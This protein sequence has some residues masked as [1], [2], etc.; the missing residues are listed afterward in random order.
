MDKQNKFLHE[1]NL[2]ES[3]SLIGG[4]PGRDTSLGYDIGWIIGM[5]FGCQRYGLSMHM[6]HIAVYMAK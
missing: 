3:L 6:Y 1:V 2:E 5:Y 4:G